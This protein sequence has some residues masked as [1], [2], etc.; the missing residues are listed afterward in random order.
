[1]FVVASVVVPG[2]LINLIS[3]YVKDINAEAAQTERKEANDQ[4][5]VEN[6]P[7]E[8]WNAWVVVSNIVLCILVAIII[9]TLRCY[10]NGTIACK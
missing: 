5:M 9:V 2:V 4:R 1:M 10:I 8:K 3:E 7:R 6:Q